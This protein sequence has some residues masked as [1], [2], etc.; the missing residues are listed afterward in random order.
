LLLEDIILG[1]SVNIEN[2]L[3]DRFQPIDI[4]QQ[5]RSL[6]S[7][8]QQANLAIGA[9]AMALA[10]GRQPEEAVMLQT[11]YSKQITELIAYAAGG[12]PDADFFIAAS[13]ALLID[14]ANQG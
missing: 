2:M 14:L 1:I 13:E 12:L 6:A 5:W 10:S 7:K 11:R 9:T 4:S 3:K 8:K